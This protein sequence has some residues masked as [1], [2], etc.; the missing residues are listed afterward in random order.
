MKIVILVLLIYL[1][2][3]G[4]TIALKRLDDYARFMTTLSNLPSNMQL[5]KVNDYFNQIVNESDSVNWGK[6]EYWA[7]PK[8]FISR[9]KGD[10][11][12]FVIAKYFAL[13][14]LGFNTKK[15][16]ILVV[17]V[18]GMNQLHAVLGVKNE[19]H[20]ILIL[21]NLSWKILSLTK[22][23]DLKIV[24]WGNESYLSQTFD[25]TPR[26]EMN[27]FKNVIQKMEKGF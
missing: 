2:V 21:D 12:D 25:T 23:H 16:M 8:E 22:R 19:T 7:T 17:R 13:K 18:D 24:R 10:C 14:E 9:G 11:E 4:D 27:A 1:S 20:D 5:E 26:P 6:E 15:M 3:K